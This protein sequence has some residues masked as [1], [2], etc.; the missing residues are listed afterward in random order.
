MS[1]KSTT[2]Q[3]SSVYAQVKYTFFSEYVHMNS[4]RQH[5]CIAH[6]VPVPRLCTHSLLS[7]QKEPKTKVVCA[8]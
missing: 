1:N 2:G 4:N 3:A 7:N 8:V 6:T 5:A